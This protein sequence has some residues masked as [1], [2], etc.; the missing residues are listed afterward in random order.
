MGSDMAA[1][2]VHVRQIRRLP[3]R[4]LFVPLSLSVRLRDNR[5]RM[6]RPGRYLGTS[7]SEDDA[8]SEEVCP[9]ACIIEKKRT[10]C[11]LHSGPVSRGDGARSTILFPEQRDSDFQAASLS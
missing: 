9:F 8:E 1:R 4:L 7:S 10:T 11:Y 3:S 2:K 6:D 5:G